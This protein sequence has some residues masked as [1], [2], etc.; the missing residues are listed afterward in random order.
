MQEEP[1]VAQLASLFTPSFLLILLRPL[2]FSPPSID[3][4]P[5]PF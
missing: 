5:F 4:V 3:I 1:A 2:H